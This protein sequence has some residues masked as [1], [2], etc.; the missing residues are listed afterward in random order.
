MSSGV[1]GSEWR[2]GSSFEQTSA[3]T[4]RS[5]KT[6]PTGFPAF[7]RVVLAVMGEIRGG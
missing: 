6:E 2:I 3:W 5:M 1:P 7:V 4:P